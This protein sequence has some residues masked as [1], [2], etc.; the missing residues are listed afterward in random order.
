LPMIDNFFELNYNIRCHH[1]IIK[2]RRNIEFLGIL[3]AGLMRAS[4]AVLLFMNSKFLESRLQ[5]KC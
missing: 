5:G 2:P 1:S 4:M 3:I